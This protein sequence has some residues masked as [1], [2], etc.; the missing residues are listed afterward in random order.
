MKLNNVYRVYRPDGCVLVAIMQNK[1]DGT[2]SFVNLTKEHIC[3]CRFISVE[4]ALKD[5]DTKIAEGSVCHY[6]KIDNFQEEVLN[7]STG[8]CRY[9]K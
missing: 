9:A 6:V 1:S 2:Y 5:M 8:S 7:E 4:A 3:S